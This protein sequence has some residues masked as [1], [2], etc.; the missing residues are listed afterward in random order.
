MA[1]WNT[2]EERQAESKHRAL[3]AVPAV[4]Q[5]ADRGEEEQHAS[6]A[7]KPGDRIKVQKSGRV[8]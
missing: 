2:A 8:R 1:Q 4:G 3:P 7:I 5:Q 6:L